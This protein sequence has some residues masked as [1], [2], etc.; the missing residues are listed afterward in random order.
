MTY[1]ALYTL[2]A[3][4]PLSTRRALLE[5][6]FGAGFRCSCPRCVAEER[7]PAIATAI[8]VAY[9]TAQK[10]SEDWVAAYDSSDAAAAAAVRDKI[11]VSD[12]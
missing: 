12:G 2:Q 10:L 7:H 1:A 6:R 5:Q 3:F 11:K 9:D 4:T 8:E